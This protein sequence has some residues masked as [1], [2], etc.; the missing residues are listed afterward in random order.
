[1]VAEP[2]FLRLFTE[3]EQATISSG[4]RLP[5]RATM[6]IA[7]K[8][9][10]VGLGIASAVL[11]PLRDRKPFLVIAVWFFVIPAEVMIDSDFVAGSAI[12]ML[13]IGALTKEVSPASSFASHP[14]GSDESLA[15]FPRVK[16]LRSSGDKLL[17]AA[18]LLV[19]LFRDADISVSVPAPLALRA[20][21][22]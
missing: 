12:E 17:G 3:P 11:A 9:F 6:V 13:G 22:R 2:L 20:A 4:H 15:A 1:M 21:R 19:F 7:S 18:R 5:S 14:V 8:G 10:F 16:M